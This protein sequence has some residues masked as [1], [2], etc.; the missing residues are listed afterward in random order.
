MSTTD[1]AAQE[2]TDD[3]TER[4]TQAIRDADADTLD[5]ERRTPDSGY[6]TH[7]AA[8]LSII[9]A[10]VRAASEK[11]W[12]EATRNALNFAYLDENGITLYL[13]PPHNRNPHEERDRSGA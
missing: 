5:Y 2:P 8:V 6:G 3:L 12:N 7:A 10:E 11:V 4:I 9:T 13:R 1:P